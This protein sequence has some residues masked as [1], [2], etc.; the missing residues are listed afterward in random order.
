MFAARAQLTPQRVDLLLLLRRETL[1]QSHLANFLCVTRSVVSRMVAALEELGLVVRSNGVDDR[2][3]R[4]ASITEAGRKRLALCFPKPTWHG[5]QDEGEIKWLRWW[6]EAMASL[7]IRVDNVLRSRQPLFFACLAAKKECNPEPR[8]LVPRELWWDWSGVCV[9]SQPTCRAP[10]KHAASSSSW[11]P[12]GVAKRSTS[13]R[14]FAAQGASQR[15][16]CERW[17]TPCP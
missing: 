4:Y 8:D 15:P 12:C 5:A 6:R 7:G 16:R 3:E 13:T 17:F 14:Y 1:K 10:R 9:A 11:A 2:R